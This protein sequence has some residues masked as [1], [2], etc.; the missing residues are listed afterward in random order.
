[1][2]ALSTSLTALIPFIPQDQWKTFKQIYP[3]FQIKSNEN[4]Y[5]TQKMEAEGGGAS[6]LASETP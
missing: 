2:H 5:T 1:M 3:S 6:P 4:V